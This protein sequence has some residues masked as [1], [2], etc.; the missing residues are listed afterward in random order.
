MPDPHLRAPQAIVGLRLR[1]VAFRTPLAMV[2]VVGLAVPALGLAFRRPAASP[3]IVLARDAGAT[4]QPIPADSLFDHDDDALKPD[5]RALIKGVADNTRPGMDVL[6][7]GYADVR[8]ADA[9]NDRLSHRRA[10][11]VCAELA[12]RIKPLACLGVGERFAHACTDQTAAD[13]RE[14][15]FAADRRVEIWTRRHLAVEEETLSSGTSGGVEHIPTAWNHPLR[16]N[17][18]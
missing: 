6:V 16:H 10:E 3:V 12:K 1:D 15:C 4:V 8:G 11:A 14:R 5:G 18:L 7:V 17:M 9:H 2:L 13:A